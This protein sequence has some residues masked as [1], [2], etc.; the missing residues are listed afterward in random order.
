MSIRDSSWFQ[1]MFGPT[2]KLITFIMETYSA[3]R[4]RMKRFKENPKIA[5]LI[6]NAAV[7]ILLIWAI[8]WIFAP[9]ESR[10][11]LTDEFKEKFIT[12]PSE[13][14]KPDQ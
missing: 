10:N 13:Q 5:S 3:N 11:R 8:I 14:N 1:F 2:I 4:E 9:E 7:I 6:R 12:P